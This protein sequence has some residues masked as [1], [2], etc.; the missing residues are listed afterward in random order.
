MEMLIKK[1]DFFEM[2][3]II[4]V[5]ESV[6]VINS[7]TCHQKTAFRQNKLMFSQNPMNIHTGRLI[8]VAILL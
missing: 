4:I 6:N 5:F 7:Y 2:R 8:G 3:Y 1:T